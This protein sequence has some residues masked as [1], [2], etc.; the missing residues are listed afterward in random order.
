MRAILDAVDALAPGSVATY[1]EI[2]D[3]AGASPRQVGQVLSRHGEEVPW[4]RVVMASGVPAAHLAERQLALLAAEGV[5]LCD[6]GTRVDWGALRHDPR[7]QELF[8]ALE[9]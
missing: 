6:G 2:A 8:G 3:A 9:V 1:G 7:Q 4:Q 5:P